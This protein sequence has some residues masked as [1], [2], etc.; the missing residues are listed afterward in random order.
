METEQVLVFP[1]RVFKELGSF[2]GFSTE[3]PHRILS[4]QKFLN[5]LSYRNRDKMEVNPCFKQIIPYCVLTTLKDGTKKYFVY[6]RTKKGGESR[7]HDK[8]SLGVGGHINPCD[9]EQTSAYQKAFLRE[10]SEEVSIFGNF[11]NEVIGAIYDD[12]NDVG[13]VHFGVVHLLTLHPDVELKTEPTLSNGQW[14]DLAWLSQNKE[15]FENWSQLV[16]DHLQSNSVGFKQDNQTQ[17]EPKSFDCFV[18]I[19]G[20]PEPLFTTNLKKNK[21]L[22]KWWKL[23]KIK[24]WSL[25]SF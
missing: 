12:S 15:R 25:F 19:A 11:E 22:I 7:L 14:V 3:A 4:N 21:S 13:K 18:K 2:T 16:I 8:W 23:F 24:F 20:N 9:G 6:Q 10:L 5:S 17:S 1:E